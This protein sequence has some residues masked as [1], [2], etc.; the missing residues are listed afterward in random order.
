M[1]SED[2]LKD[3]AIQSVAMAPPSQKAIPGWLLLPG[4][5]S[6]EACPK[7][8]GLYAFFFLATSFSLTPS[9]FVFLSAAKKEKA[10]HQ[11]RNQDN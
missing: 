2:I 3:C 10:L 6:G 11:K 1:E 8:S 9:S 4:W 5:H 7:S